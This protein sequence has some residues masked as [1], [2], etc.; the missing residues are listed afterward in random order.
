MR[1]K[2]GDRPIHDAAHDSDTDAC[3]GKLASEGV[4]STRSTDRN[5]TYTTFLNLQ[6]MWFH[7]SVVLQHA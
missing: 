2:Q 3:H 4:S 5:F 6:P 7:Y 1:E